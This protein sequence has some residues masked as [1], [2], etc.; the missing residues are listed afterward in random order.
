MKILSITTPGGPQ[1][2]AIREAEVPKPSATQV[3]IKV[4]AAGLNRA[5][6]LQRQGKYPPPPGA[7]EHPGMEVAGEIVACGA[8]VREFA[9]GQRVCALVPGGGYAEFCAAD[10]G[11]ILP[12]PDAMS[13]VD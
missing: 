4:Q 9:M 6:L 3:L 1:V 13:F 10:E 5:D 7:P 12:V 8:E 11:Q 2:L